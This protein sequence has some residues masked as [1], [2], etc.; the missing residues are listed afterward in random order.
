MRYAGDAT[1][2]DVRLVPDIS[3]SAPFTPIK[4]YENGDYMPYV[5]QRSTETGALPDINELIRI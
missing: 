2:T 5:P 4:Q 1:N 3:F